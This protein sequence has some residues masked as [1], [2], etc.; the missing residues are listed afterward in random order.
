MHDAEAMQ[1]L[2]LHSMFKQLPP[3]MQHDVLS[4]LAFCTRH[5]IQVDVQ[6]SLN[7]GEEKLVCKRSELF[8]AIREAFADRATAR[9][10]AIKGGGQGELKITKCDEIWS[11][12]I[13]VE[14]HRFYLFHA[15][16]LSPVVN[17]RLES[18]SRL[19]ANYRLDH[20]SAARWQKLLLER[21]LDAHEMDA[22]FDDV[23]QTPTAVA[24]NISAG[25]QRGVFD[26]TNAVPQSPAYYGRLAGG[27]RATTSLFD[28]IQAE[29]A[30]YLERLVQ[31]DGVEGIKQALLLSAHSGIVAAIPTDHLS[32]AEIISLYDWLCEQG[33]LYSLLG[34]IELAFRMLNFKPQLEPYLVRLVKLITQVGN[35]TKRGGWALLSALIV[36]V[37]GELART[38]LLAER[39][40]FARRLAA[41]AQA[42]LIERAIY[43]QSVNIDSLAKYAI[44]ARGAYFFFQTFADLRLEPWWQSDYLSQGQLKAEFF[45]RIVMAATTH[46]S[47]IQD[48]SLRVLIAENGELPSLLEDLN[49]FLPGPLEGGGE[50]LPQLPSEVESKIEQL[51]SSDIISSDAVLELI[52]FVPICQ[53]TDRHAELVMAALRRTQYGIDIS[54]N[55]DKMAWMLRGLGVLAATTRC[56]ALASDVRILTRRWRNVVTIESTLERETSI[57]L[58]AAAANADLANWCE[59]IGDWLSELSFLPLDE[60]QSAYLLNVVEALCDLVPELWRYCGRAH[61]ALMIANEVA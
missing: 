2:V 4:D 32:E 17:E 41:I 23:M 55:T 16:A 26:L 18:F 33:D 29:V 30:P 12:V 11:A 48:A 28:H 58:T 27:Y 49:P 52:N 60:K 46:S 10:L 42:A 45:G 40:P 24:K 59:F 19:V 56:S 14:N 53:I 25:F 21:P 50:T 5:D 47:A 44:E 43:G 15:F 37:D 20:D 54:S 39:A 22:L 8:R 51:M 36:A 7:Q 61:A 3:T 13:T 57:C 34:G 31:A 35:D 6:V 38:K 1:A 9:T